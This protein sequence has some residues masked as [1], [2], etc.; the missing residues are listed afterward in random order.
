MTR[1]RSELIT[2]IL[3]LL[4]ILPISAGCRGPHRE[5]PHP[6]SAPDPR[7]RVADAPTQAPPEPARS[8]GAQAATD[9]SPQRPAG[10]PAGAFWVGGP[11]GGVFVFLE[12]SS[13]RKGSLVG[14]IYHPDGELWYAG[15][16]V[17]K[18]AGASVD[19][20]QHDQFAGWDGERL[21]MTEGRW[22]ESAKLKRGNA[23]R[24]H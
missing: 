21:L 5:D 2:A 10:V 20:S 8:A 12:P 4:A 9:D 7:D 13:D 3:A 11:D 23:P 19:P 6:V 14:K 18:P 24:A 17:P 16:L 1:V 15:P 22:L